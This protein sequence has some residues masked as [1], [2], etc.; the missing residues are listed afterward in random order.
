MAKGLAHGEKQAL[1]SARGVAHLEVKGKTS[2][3]GA[4]DRSLSACSLAA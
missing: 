3:K 1:S 4:L 2:T